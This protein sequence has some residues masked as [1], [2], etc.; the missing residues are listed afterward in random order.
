MSRPPI[1]RIDE[2]VE[3]EEPELSA[4]EADVGGQ[5]HVALSKANHVQ[6]LAASTT[7]VTQVSCGAEHSFAISDQGDLYSWGL[8]F[9]GQLGMQD[10][11]S[12]SRPTL[13]K[14]LSPSF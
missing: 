4:T 3:S 2:F 10:F 5:T 14:N 11:E 7:Q 6:S 9:K 1:Y 13:V 8:N 12:R